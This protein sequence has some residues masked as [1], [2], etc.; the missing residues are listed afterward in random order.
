V[1]RHFT[2]QQAEA[3]LKEVERGLRQA[4]ALRQEL[5]GVLAGLAEV[6]RHVSLSGGALVDREQ[7]RAVRARRAD[8]AQGLKAAVEA[9]QSC[10]CLI[11]D[12][13]AGLV[14]FPA[15]FCGREVYL[16][17]RLGEDRIGF[18]HEVED[19]FRGRRPIDRYFLDHHAGDPLH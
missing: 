1:A 7:L 10:G 13:N 2:L 17:W 12:L 19:G 4:V 6:A 16:C 18:W 9:V 5:A 3:V 14:D 15:W 11:K 8:L